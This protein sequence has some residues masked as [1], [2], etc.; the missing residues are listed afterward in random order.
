M[1][2]LSKK[3]KPQAPRIYVSACGTI[4][5]PFEMITTKEKFVKIWKGKCKGKDINKLW[6]EAERTRKQFA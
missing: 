5:M 6:L 4:H 2:D 1:E 3:T